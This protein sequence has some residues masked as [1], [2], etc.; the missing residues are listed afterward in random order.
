VRKVKKVIVLIVFTVF[1]FGSPPAF[2][3][4]LK[5]GESLV[6]GSIEFSSHKSI[7]KKDGKIDVD[8]MSQIET[9]SCSKSLFESFQNNLTDALIK[10]GMKIDSSSPIRM[11]IDMAYKVSMIST[12]AAHV[13]MFSPEGKLFET[14]GGESREI[15]PAVWLW[16]KC[17]TLSLMKVNWI[18]VASNNVADVV[19]VELRKNGSIYPPASISNQ[20]SIDKK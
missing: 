12:I 10:R 6:I 1:L 3:E 11:K 18:N 15:G 8:L 16:G 19:V 2:A 7:F 9:S 13:S 20:A 5:T 17:A 4:N 14:S